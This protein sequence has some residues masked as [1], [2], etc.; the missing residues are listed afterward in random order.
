[1][2]YT[3]TSITVTGA[4]QFLDLQG[5]SDRRI[6]RK[7]LPYTQYNWHWHG[8]IGYRDIFHLVN[9]QI[10]LG[11]TKLCYWEQLIKT[12]IHLNAS[13]SLNNT[14]ENTNY[15]KL[16]H[17]ESEL[18]NL[19]MTFD[20]HRPLFLS[21]TVSVWLAVTWLITGIWHIMGSVTEC[22]TNS[23]FLTDCTSHPHTCQR[24]VQTC[25]SDETDLNTQ[26]PSFKRA[27]TLISRESPVN[28]VCFLFSVEIWL[29]VAKA[30]SVRAVVAC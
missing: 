3:Q 6:V 10:R 13:H 11:Y 9:K 27:G 2:L 1:M 7:S 12:Q 14:G 17:S 16:G 26:H 15:W 25:R 28:V 8:C 29:C 22:H 18:I 20:W 4:K 19:H 23:C 24:Q 21:I 5:G 30:G